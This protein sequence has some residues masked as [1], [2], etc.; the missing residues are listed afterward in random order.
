[1]DLCRTNVGVSLL[2]MGPCKSPKTLNPEPFLKNPA[3]PLQLGNAWF[4]LQKP[5]R[6]LRAFS[7]ITETHSG[8]L[9]E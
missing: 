2:A 3:I 5:G 9:F 6:K 7:S 4:T 8:Y 1:M